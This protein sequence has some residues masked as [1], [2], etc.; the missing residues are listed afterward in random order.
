MHGL[1]NVGAALL[2]GTSY[3]LRKTGNRG[4]ARALSFTGFGVV[5]ASAYL[6]GALS[7]R[8]RIGVDHSADT[9]QDLPEEYT[10]VCNESE[11]LEGKPRKATGQGADVVL[12]RSGEQVFALGEKCSH[13]GGPLSEGDVKDGSIVCPWHGSRFCLKTGSVLDGPATHPQPKLEVS[14]R[15]GRVLVRKD[16]S[17]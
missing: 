6:G 9:E 15:N 12:V 8:Q 2:Y 7:Y 17:A 14:I 3:A 11:L 5:L 16:P 10:D 4:L 1:L 13:L